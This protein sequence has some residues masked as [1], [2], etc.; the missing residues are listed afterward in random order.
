MKEF[1]LALDQGTTSSRAIIFNHDG[2]PVTVAQKEFHYD[3]SFGIVILQFESRK[4]D[5]FWNKKSTMSTKCL[6]PSRLEHSTFT[7]V[8]FF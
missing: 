7:E 4:F 8:I 6:T 3:V 5:L 1:I 2:L